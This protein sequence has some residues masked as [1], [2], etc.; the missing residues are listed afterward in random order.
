[1]ATPVITPPEPTQ[2]ISD[3]ARVPG[4]LFSPGA[5]FTDI[6]RK[7]SWLLPIALVTVL[8]LCVTYF[9]NQKM[10]WASFQRTQMEKRSGFQNL[11]A[12]R[13]R[14]TGGNRCEISLQRLHGSPAP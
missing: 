14:P 4:V 8:S 12:G 1:M 5:T 13:Q 9:L 3:F 2:Q 11:S 6:A 10:D 7:A